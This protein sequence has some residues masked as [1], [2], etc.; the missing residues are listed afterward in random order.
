MMNIQVESSLKS[1]RLPEISR[2]YKVA[3]EKFEKSKDGYVNYLNYL[4]EAE[5]Q[6]RYEKRINRLLKASNLN[7][8][9]TIDSFN[10][11]SIDISLCTKIKILKEGNW[12][13]KH[14]NILAFGTPGSGKTHLVS[15]IAREMI[16]LGYS[17]YFTSCSNLI[18]MLLKSKRDYDLNKKLKS[19]RKFDIL[20]LDD[21]G[22]IQQNEEEMEVLFQLLADRYEQASIMIT[23]NL[24]FSKWDKIFKNPMTTAAAVDRLVHHCV[25]LE[26]NIESYRLKA[27]KKSKNIE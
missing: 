15:A 3:A 17:V 12:V 18:Q 10:Q 9:K 14:E 2:T 23:S 13:K 8:T 25:I 4:C 22:Y 6:S 27:S 16:F 1:L 11:E 20:V 5:L 21:I 19:L 7:A 24:P 26:M